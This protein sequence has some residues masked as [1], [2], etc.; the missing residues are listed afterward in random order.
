M[1]MNPFA[2]LNIFIVLDS[3][4]PKYQRSVNV[5]SVDKH[6]FIQQH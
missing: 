3:I 6:P 5:I 2:L 4:L 1:F